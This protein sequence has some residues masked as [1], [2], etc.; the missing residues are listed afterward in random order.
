[1]KIS[2]FKDLHTDS[3]I[4]IRNQFTIHFTRMIG[5]MINYSKIKNNSDYLKVFKITTQLSIKSLR[6]RQMEMR[7]N[8]SH[9]ISL[10][11][12]EKKRVLKKIRSIRLIHKRET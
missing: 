9:T 1:M 7:K 3:N 4:R 6:N 11:K 10:M 12:I 2:N 5:I 8:N